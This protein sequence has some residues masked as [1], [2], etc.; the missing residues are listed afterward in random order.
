MNS[1]QDASLQ[2]GRLQANSELYFVKMLMKVDVQ[3]GFCNEVV[4]Y[5]SI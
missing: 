4:L 1:T 5:G 2:I 3:I